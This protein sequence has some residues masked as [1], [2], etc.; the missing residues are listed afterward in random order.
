M[1]SPKS[2]VDNLNAINAEDT[3]KSAKD[4]VNSLRHPQGR[5]ASRFTP[6]QFGVLCFVPRASSST[7]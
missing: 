6:S 5:G 7:A 2:Q 4:N 1:H 3:H